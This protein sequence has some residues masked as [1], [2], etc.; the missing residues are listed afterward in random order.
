[1]EKRISGK[2][3]LLGLI[4]SP[5]EHSTSPAMY[6]LSFQLLGLDY[7]YLA[8]DIGLEQLSTAL[9]AAKLFNFKGLNVTMPCKI[10]ASKWMDELSPA[11]RIIG[12]VN[13]IVID[14]GK[15]YGYNTDGVGYVQNLKEHNVDVKSK[16]ITI[17]GAGGAGTAVQVQCALD[18]ASEISI[19]NPR[20]SFFE[21]AQETARRIVKE[22]PDCA[23]Q[24]Y[25]LADADALDAE[26]KSSQILI[27]AT[28]AGMAPDVKSTNIRKKEVFRKD[29]I[30]TDVIYNPEETLMLKEAREAGCR[31]IG[32]KGMLFQQGVEAFKLFTGRTMPLEEIR[33]AFFS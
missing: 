6:N 13:T 24:V 5:V 9:E 25:D 27:N 18:G 33:E 26:I 7:A 12:A 3:Q 32:G 23:I 17:L 21:K 30:V 14:S 28:K 2:T 15:L 16:K 19:F 10:E 4:G 8:F 11:A 22:K 1:M 29:L 31:T 20:D